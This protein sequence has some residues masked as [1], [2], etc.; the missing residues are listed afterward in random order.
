MQ[1]FVLPHCC[2]A[3]NAKVASSALA[4]AIVRKY[5]PDRLEKA[6]SEYEKKWSQFSD[7]FKAS[8]PESFQRMF[9]SD[10][11]DS[12]SFWQNLCTITRNP[13]LPVLLLIRNPVDR[14]LS[15]ASYLSQDIDKLLTALEKDDEEYVL[16]SLPIKITK[17]THFIKQSWLIK[18]DTRLYS[19]PEQ[20]QQFCRDAGLE[21]PLQR[22]NEGKNIKPVLTERQIKR[23]EA[24]YAEDVELWKL[25]KLN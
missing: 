3:F 18:G 12:I 16:E 7:E 23:I 10:M 5:H 8:L 9:R 24:Y 6:L 25:I 11:N 14:F 22:V 4:S 15:G 19:F 1:Y 20:L 17:N 2:I 13:E 21:W